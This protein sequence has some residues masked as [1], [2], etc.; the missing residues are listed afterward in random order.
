[1]GEY[2][3]S[4]YPITDLAADERPWKRLSGLGLRR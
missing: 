3:N 1:M 2:G 4:V